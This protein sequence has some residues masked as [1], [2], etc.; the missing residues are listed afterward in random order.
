MLSL[1][2]AKSGALIG[3]LVSVTTIPAAA[4]IGVAAAYAE[5]GEFRGAV[6]QLALNLSAIFLAG[7]ATL[8]IER[9]LYV[10]RRRRHLHDAAREHA[11]LPIGHSRRERPTKR[12]PVGE[13]SRHRAPT[14]P[15]CSA[16]S[17]GRRRSRRRSAPP[18]SAPRSP[19]ASS[20][21]PRP[22]SG[23][24]CGASSGGSASSSSTRRRSA[25]VVSLRF[26]SRRGLEQD[27][28]ARRLDQ[29]RVVGGAGAIGGGRVVDAAQRLG[30]EYLRRLGGP[31]SPRG[32]RWRGS[33]SRRRRRA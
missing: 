10:R 3:V 26:S 14:W 21:S 20:P 17:P 7:V 15:C 2:S 16:A 19:S 28:A 29:H 9:L 5:W 31:Q 4:N 6:L 23:C 11:G 27:P 33:R 32:A 30:A 24:C 8:F 12:T 25:G 22:W 18:T 13:V 1:T